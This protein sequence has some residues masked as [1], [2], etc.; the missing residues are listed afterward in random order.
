MRTSLRAEFPTLLSCNLQSSINGKPVQSAAWL[1]QCT[2]NRF[3]MNLLRD[4]LLTCAINRYFYCGPSC[5]FIWEFTWPIAM[6]GS[7]MWPDW[8]IQIL[9][10]VGFLCQCLGHEAQALQRVIWSKADSTCMELGVSLDSGVFVSRVGVSQ[11]AVWPV[12][13]LSDLAWWQWGLP[14][15]ICQLSSIQTSYFQDN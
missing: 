13:C 2:L 8:A 3:A 15:H 9:V 6:I 4:E 10:L 5:S 1:L 12:S 14:Q 7:F 11:L